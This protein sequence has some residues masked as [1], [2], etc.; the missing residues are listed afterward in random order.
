MNQQ[1]EHAAQGRG[2]IERSDLFAA[3]GGQ[4]RSVLQEE[5]HVRTECRRD[6]IELPAAQRLAKKFVQSKERAGRVAAAAAQ[7]GG[8][9]KSLLQ[10]DAHTL[11]GAPRLQERRRGRR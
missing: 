8:E 3:T 9:R 10:M 11:G 7:A 6:F 1:N 2:K 4:G 5:R